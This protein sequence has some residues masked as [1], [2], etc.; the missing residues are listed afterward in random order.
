MNETNIVEM[1]FRF[2]S[3]I[4]NYLFPHTFKDGITNEALGV[5]NGA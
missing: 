2:A 3:Q 4:I 1:L 5:F